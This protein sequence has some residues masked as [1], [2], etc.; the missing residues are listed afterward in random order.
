MS[1]YAGIFLLLLAQVA[2]IDA[3]TAKTQKAKTQRAPKSGKTLK[4][5][6]AQ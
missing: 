1:K 6:I 4:H 5:T 3:I 2:H